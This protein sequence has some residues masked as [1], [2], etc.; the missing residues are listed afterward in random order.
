MPVVSTTFRYNRRLTVN[1]NQK[2]LFSSFKTLA[3]ISSPSWRENDLIDWLEAFAKKRK[4]AFKKFACRKSFNVLMTIKATD[5]SMD[6]LLFSGHTDT[7]PPCD[8]VK[9]IET[10]TKFTSDGSTIL[11]GDDK[12]AIAAFVEAIDVILENKTAH[13]TLHF[14]LTCAEEVGLEGM[15]G[16]DFSKISPAPRFAF[17][18]DMGGAIGTACIKAPWHT[19]THVT[20]YGKAAHAGMEPEKGINAIKA[21]AAIISALPD[22]R[23]DHETTCNVGLV[24]GGS[25]TNIVAAE[26]SF[27]CES[28][29]LDK[30]KLSALDKKTAALIKQAAKK[31][32]VKVAI[33]SVLEYP[34]YAVK[35][36]SPILKHF[37]KACRAVSLQPNFI[38][39]GGG[40]DVNILRGAK[41]DAINVSVGMSKV[42][43]TSEELKK[44]DLVDSCRLV[45][46]II[47][48]S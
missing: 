26:A 33:K 30:A 44:S 18:L 29:S 27:D 36:G 15:K 21:M 2:R 34:G 32:G 17:V 42:H 1:I 47:Q 43:T 13:G 20:V 12:A 45:L 48:Q 39:A 10:E 41:I 14:L 23:I 40:S 31:A 5:T 4:I 22:G 25:A 37:E 11:G 7:V 28:R 46:A 16:M 24:R 8:K 19:A 6:T 38:G 3:Q 35:A 9:V